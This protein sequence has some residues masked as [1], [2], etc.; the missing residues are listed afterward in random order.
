MSELMK[1]LK[2]FEAVPESPAFP[3][4][5]AVNQAM[6]RHWCDAME[7]ANP[8]YTDSE[9]AKQS[10]HGGVVAP[11]TMLQ[12]WTM[13]GLVRL[14]PHSRSGGGPGLF[15]LLD[16]AGFTSVVATNCRQEY[17]RYLEPG[18]LISVSMSISD[19]SEEKETGLG[20]GHFVTQRHTFRDQ[21]GDVVGTMDFRILKFRPKARPPAAPAQPTRRQRPRPAMNQDSE[22]FWKG[23]A[24]GRLLVQRCLECGRLRHPPEPVCTACGSF[25]LEAAECSGR[26]SVYSYVVMHHPPIPPFEYPNPIALVELEEGVR[27]VA[28]LKDVVPDEVEIGMPVEAVFEP[29]ATDDDLVVPLFRRA[30]A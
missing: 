21:N 17:T 1:R 22:F 20:A 29:V 8:V 23:L 12:A 4:R 5:D 6:I 18:D 7:D 14:P 10:V 15:Q 9:R 30:G 2:A 24:E 27:M 13:R 28:N 19:V 25:D 3:A 16:E 26:G 11:P